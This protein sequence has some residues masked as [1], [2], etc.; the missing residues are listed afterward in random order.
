MTI[1]DPTT[2]RPIRQEQGKV[3]VQGHGWT[4]IVTLVNGIVAKVE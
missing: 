1:I 3:Q 2:M 4:G